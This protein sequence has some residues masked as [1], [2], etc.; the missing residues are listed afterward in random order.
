[1]S[2]KHLLNTSVLEASC[3]EN[4][5]A[6]ISF[7][8]QGP[9]SFINMRGDA[10]QKVCRIHFSLPCFAVWGRGKFVGI[11]LTFNSIATTD[12]KI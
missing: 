8:L 1:M 4:D 5:H 10:E 11:C 3:L 7:A 12:S 9:R 6:C 2:I